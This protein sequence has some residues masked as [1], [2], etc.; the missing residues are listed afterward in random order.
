MNSMLNYA[1]ECSFL[2]ENMNYGL[3]INSQ[4]A[5]KD[6]KNQILRMFG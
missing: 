4:K 5:L 2:A 1:V 6:A 3:K